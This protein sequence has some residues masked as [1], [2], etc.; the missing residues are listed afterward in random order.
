MQVPTAMSDSVL[1]FS[2]TCI[3]IVQSTLHVYLSMRHPCYSNRLN[4]MCMSKSRFSGHLIL[5]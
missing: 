4:L 1:P 3:W 5:Q 2:V